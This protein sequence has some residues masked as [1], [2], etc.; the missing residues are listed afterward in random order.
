MTNAYL[1]FKNLTMVNAILLLLYGIG[2]IIIPENMLDYYG[3][4]LSNDGDFITKL[5][6]AT[7]ISLA[8]I[9]WAIRDMEFSDI[10]K[11]ISIG[12]I[13]GSG[14]GGILSLINRFD[15]NTNANTLEWLN[16][17]LYGIFAAGY[18]YFTFIETGEK[19]SE[20]SE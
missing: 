19:K 20:T 12:I 7:Y 10:R 11:N 4:S 18:A 3:V 6:G 1:T 17:F 2:F 9:V 16:V 15:D 13:V 5:W 14:I 8:M